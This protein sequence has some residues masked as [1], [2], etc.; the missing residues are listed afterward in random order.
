MI[1]L[2]SLLKVNVSLLTCRSSLSVWGDHTGH[3]KKK[4]KLRCPFGA[5]RVPEKKKSLSALLLPRTMWSPTRSPTWVAVWRAVLR[6]HS[7]RRTVCSKY[8]SGPRRGH[9]VRASLRVCIPRQRT[10][11]LSYRASGL[12][13]AP[14]SCL[15][16][17]RLIMNGAERRTDG[18]GLGWGCVWCQ[19]CWSPARLSPQF[20]RVSVVAHTK[21][22]HQ[23]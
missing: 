17:Q 8:E 6:V 16:A 23:T 12:T 14:E 5:Q 9:D 10:T 19:L 18:F 4:E 7:R 13:P 2:L 15:G 21:G 20:L 11:A 3:M 1:A 22:R